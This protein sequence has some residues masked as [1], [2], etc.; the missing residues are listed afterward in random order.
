MMT[1]F[2]LQALRLYFSNPRAFIGA[3]LQL[4]H[5][6]SAEGPHGL[7]PLL[8]GWVGG[9][10]REYG[11]GSLVRNP[12]CRARRGLRVVCNLLSVMT[13]YLPLLFSRNLVPVRASVYVRV[14]VRAV[15][16]RA[17]LLVFE[18]ASAIQVGCNMHTYAS[19][20]YAHSTLMAKMIRIMRA[21][22]ASGGIPSGVSKMMDRALPADTLRCNQS[23]PANQIRKGRSIQMLTECHQPLTVAYHRPIQTAKPS[24]CH[25]HAGLPPLAGRR[26]MNR[27][28]TQRSS[29]R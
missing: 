1:T 12:T 9:C 19:E 25:G 29:T 27:E 23:Y 10:Q 7:L 3:H 8:Q 14:C 5:D 18:R 6:V 21:S 13:T 2:T 26:F 20:Y 16:V 22:A 24:Q 4:S 11:R 28:S 17:C 15:C